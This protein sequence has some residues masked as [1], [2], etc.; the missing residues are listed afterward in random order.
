VDKY[1]LEFAEQNRLLFAIKA[2]YMHGKKAWQ[3]FCRVQKKQDSE[4]ACDTL[5]NFFAINLSHKEMDGP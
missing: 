2:Q 1:T 5:P 3:I 4:I